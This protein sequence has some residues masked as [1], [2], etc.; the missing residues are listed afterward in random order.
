MAL[1]ISSR[2]SL[3]EDSIPRNGWVKGWVRGGLITS[4]N[5]YISHVA[6]QKKKKRS[7]FFLGGA[8]G[9][10]PSTSAKDKG[11]DARRAAER[12]FASTSAQG[13]S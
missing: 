11:A 3:I 4:F 5:I 7:V 12:S 1:G 6:K 10:E 8:R 9:G 2:E 13:I